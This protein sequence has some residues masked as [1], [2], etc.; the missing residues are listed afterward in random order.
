L[1]WDTS[2]GTVQQ[3][4]PAKGL[5][6]KLGYAEDGSH[7][8]TDLESL[9]IQSGRGNVSSC[10]PRVN[11]EMIALNGQWITIHGD[12]VL[13]LPPEYRPR[14]SAVKDNTLALGHAS[15]RISFI[16]FCSE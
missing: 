12:R 6:I 8:C 3:D 14:C 15:G 2:T 7:L 16:R 4:I 1:L 13:W 5:A 10:F 9:N 11:A